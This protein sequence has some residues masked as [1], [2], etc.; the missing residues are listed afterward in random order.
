MVSLGVRESAKES[1]SEPIIV[2]SVSGSYIFGDGA[3]SSSEK[4]GDDGKGEDE[5]DGKGEEQ[6]VMEEDRDD[7]S[8]DE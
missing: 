5:E 6:D 2:R 3:R 4:I 8:G 7:G 1:G